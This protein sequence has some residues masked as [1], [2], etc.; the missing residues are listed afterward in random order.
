MIVLIL[1]VFGLIFGSFVNAYVWRF[2]KRKNW[3]SE[4]SICPNCKHVLRAKDLVPVLSWLSLRG[5]C[6]YCKKPISAQY[7]AVELFTALLFALSYAFWPYS[8]TLLGWLAFISWLG[9]LVVFM[10]LLVYDLKWKLLPNK[11]VLPLTILASILVTLLAIL[12]SSW[13]GLF[14]SVVSGLVFF[15]IFWAL[16]QVSDGR[17]IGG[18]D[19]KM[20]YALGLIAGSIIN[21]FLLIFLASVIG[22]FL[23]LPLLVSKKLNARSKIPFGP[24]LIIATIIVFLFGSQ[25]IDWYTKTF[26]FMG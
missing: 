5:K 10:A 2:K 6:R 18:G 3:V 9:C 21:V 13:L 24:L 7:P 22:T 23:V 11:M 16:F 26:L 20:S 8:L 19:V 17:W 14:W 12:N 15:A 1:F 25:M 4:R